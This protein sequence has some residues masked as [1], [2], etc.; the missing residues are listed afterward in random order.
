MSPILELQR[1]LREI[2][3]IRIGQTVPGTSKAGKAINRPIKLDTFRL[4]SRDPKL[5][6]AAAHLYGGK[7][8]PWDGQHEV[9]TDTA[10]LNIAIPPGGVAFTQW[11]ELWSSGGCQRRCDGAWDN[12]NDKPCV[13]DP[14]A[15]DCSIHTRLSVVLTD[16]PGLGVW[17]LDTQGWYA[18]T[19]LSQVIELLEHA[20]ERGRF[21][22]ARLRLEQR[23]VRRVGADVRKFAVPTVDLD[24]RLMDMRGLISSNDHEQPAIEPSNIRQLEPARETRDERPAL[25]PVPATFGGPSIAEQIKAD[26]QRTR[27][28]RA[29]QL[30]ATGLQPTPVA[31]ASRGGT[32][33][34]GG[35]D[36]GV[37]E[38]APPSPPMARDQR[39]KC[40]PQNLHK[41]WAAMGNIHGLVGADIEVAFDA[42][43]KSH[44]AGRTTSANELTLTEADLLS[45]WVDLLGNGNSVIVDDDQVVLTTPTS[46]VVLPRAELATSA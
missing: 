17:R 33:P 15:R 40:N 46:E 39:G 8:Q 2:G 14:E 9:I 26:E 34:V 32:A 36:D 20:A 22:P 11:Y 16:L 13:C 18:A 29:P 44:T 19:E 24:V 21:L 31:Q 28:T 12:V 25:T 27:Q 6:S 41:R 5:I 7:P 30:P 3:R 1:R 35:E 10:E 42:L 23:E 38:V 4:T 43:V 37:G 45:E